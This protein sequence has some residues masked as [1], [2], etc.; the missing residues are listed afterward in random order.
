LKWQNPKKL[1]KVR[2]M[3]RKIRKKEVRKKKQLH[4]QMT[5]ESGFSHKDRKSLIFSFRSSS[6]T[7]ETVKSVVLQ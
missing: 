3:K 2:K 1:R 7:T 5:L 6:T 4:E